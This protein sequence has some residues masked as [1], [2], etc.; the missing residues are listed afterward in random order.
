VARFELRWR[1]A[2][3][4]YRRSSGGKQIEPLENPTRFVDKMHG[5]QKVRHVSAVDR[6]AGMP[7]NAFFFG[8]R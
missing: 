4:S 3:T 7:I 6:A 2:K 5:R 1:S 8:M